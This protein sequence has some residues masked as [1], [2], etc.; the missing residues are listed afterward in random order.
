MQSTQQ[1][2]SN[3]VAG[4]DARVRM[5]YANATST[6]QTIRYKAD[7]TIASQTY[8]YTKNALAVV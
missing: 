1:K 4:A 3:I 8:G 7:A 6:A 5:I 2:T